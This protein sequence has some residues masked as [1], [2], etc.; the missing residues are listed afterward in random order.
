MR[1]FIYRWWVCWEGGYEER[2]LGME[3]GKKWGRGPEARS[4]GVW[5]G[6]GVL[7]YLILSFFC[8]GFCELVCV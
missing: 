8:V 6:F 3:V 4:L 7:K 2:G 5:G 1:D